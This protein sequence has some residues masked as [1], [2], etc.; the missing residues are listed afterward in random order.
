MLAPADLSR[1]VILG[2]GGSGKSWLAERLAEQL[3]SRAIDLDL[4]HWLPGGF[5][6]R[7]D[8]DE[9]RAAV[10]QLAME[11]RWI[12]EGV[13]GWLARE[14]LP[15]A[16]ALILLDIPDDECV[17][18][19]QSRG[20]RRGGD[21]AAHNALVEWLREYRTRTNSNGFQAHM[22]LHSGF[23]GGKVILRSRADLAAQVTAA[24]A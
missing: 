8:P 9:A 5:N 19:V 7:R 14:A 11:D 24:A 17:A 1:T 3:S 23:A 20:L 15:R 4:V 22:D 13:Y 10:R 21:E 16:S 18:N 2:N 12:I 6:D